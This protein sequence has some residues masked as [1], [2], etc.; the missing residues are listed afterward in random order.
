MADSISANKIDILVKDN[1]S[2]IIV[3][4]WFSQAYCAYAK[5][6]VLAVQKIINSEDVVNIKSLCRQLGFPSKFIVSDMDKTSGKVYVLPANSS[7][8][9]CT[10]VEEVWS[11]TPRL[12]MSKVKV[13]GYCNNNGKKPG[14]DMEW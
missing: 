1:Q 14:K 7:T 12:T 13:D 3:S 8:G 5:D 10:M 11:G 4:Y 9:E 6:G 2:V